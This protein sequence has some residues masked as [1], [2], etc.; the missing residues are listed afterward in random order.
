[1]WKL[2]QVKG[3]EHIEGVLKYWGNRQ[4]HWVRGRGA[5][6]R[7]HP[8]SVAPQQLSRGPPSETTRHLCKGRRQVPNAPNLFED[9][10]E[11]SEASSEVS[12]KESHGQP[13]LPGTGP[14][15]SVWRNELEFQNDF[16]RSPAPFHFSFSK[17]LTIHVPG[18]F[19]GRLPGL[20]LFCCQHVESIPAAVTTR[21]L[22]FFRMINDLTNQG[23][24][25][26]GERV[27]R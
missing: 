13:S 2:C 11:L 20:S 7:A 23:Y 9:Q 10:M 6:L 24:Y 15:A 3:V 17:H 5:R 27:R 16:C 21:S 14:S 8:S 1:M 19:P 22:T 4:H 26:G 12:W 18:I 25:E